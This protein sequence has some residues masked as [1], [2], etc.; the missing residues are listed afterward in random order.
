MNTAANAKDAARCRCAQLA[1]SKHDQKRDLPFSC[2]KVGIDAQE[3][4]SMQL[5]DSKSANPQVPLFHSD[6]S[7][8]TI[9]IVGPR[10]SVSDRRKSVWTLAFRVPLLIG[11]LFAFAEGC[12]TSAVESVAGGEPQTT[13]LRCS[14]YANAFSLSSMNV[15]SGT[16][17]TYSW[18]FGRAKAINVFSEASGDEWSV[19]GITTAG[20]SSPLQHQLYSTDLTRGVSSLPGSSSSLTRGRAHLVLVTAIDGIHAGCAV[21]TP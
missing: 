8:V 18:N 20:F 3:T 9:W 21:F 7:K 1:L 19:I 14:A 6:C 4:M 15:S 10:W 2:A 12:G 5:A 13:S 11:S 17:P 16:Q